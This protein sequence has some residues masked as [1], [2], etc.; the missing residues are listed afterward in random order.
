MVDIICYLTGSLLLAI[1]ALDVFLTI[2]YAR[3]GVSLLSARS[4]KGIWLIF[5]RAALTIPS[6]KNMTLSFCGPFLMVFNLALWAGLL[7]VGF[8]LIVWPQL[9][10]AVTSSQGTTGRGF[11]TAFF[12]S[13]YTFTTLG[14][15]DLQPRTDLFRFLSVLESA[16][17]FIYFTMTITYF[18]SVYTAIQNRNA[19][20][21]RLHHKTGG[22]A[23]AAVYL[24]GMRRTRQVQE[25]SRELS[26]DAASLSELQES[27]HLYPI[28]HYFRFKESRYALP[29]ILAICLE[30]ASLARSLG[31]ADCA[32]FRDSA[33]PGQLWT[34]TLDLLSTLTHSFLP[35]KFHSH[36]ESGDPVDPESW[37]RR[38]HKAIEKID[39]SLSETELAS[40]EKAY[41]QLR[42]QWNP[43][44]VAFCR[45][46]VYTLEE[47][48]P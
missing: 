2:L 7:I 9:G 44:I 42:R 23:D 38:F 40:A 46:Q 25:V 30:T 26:Q 35:R 41:K 39:G 16:I 47:I 3:N 28:L 17:G 1:A 14:L 4:N 18:L 19:L 10:A 31:E 20:A 43:F 27:H 13:G 33:A 24:A 36:I 15:G 34:S 21:L 29:R 12:Y 5:R 48:M 22:T 37:H 6:R 32:E 8:C 11:W 45:S